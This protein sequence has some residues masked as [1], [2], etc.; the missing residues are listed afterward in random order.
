M[1]GVGI[2]AGGLQLPVNHRFFGDDVK[3]STFFD[4]WMIGELL[5]PR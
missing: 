3:M 2:L 1:V 5:W 4:G